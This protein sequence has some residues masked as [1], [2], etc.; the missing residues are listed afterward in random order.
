MTETKCFDPKRW[1]QLRGGSLSAPPPQLTKE[2]KKTEDRQ[3][4]VKSKETKKIELS[5]YESPA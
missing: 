2:M 1:T 5:C 3:N 4:K